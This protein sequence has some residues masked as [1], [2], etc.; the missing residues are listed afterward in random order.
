VR[1]DVDRLPD[2]RTRVA[3]TGEIDMS[4][5]ADV[6]QRIEAATRLTGEVVVDLRPL[7]YLDSQGVRILQRLVNRHV[8]GAVDVT[9]VATRG[10]IVAD[11][12][13]MT[14]LG[15]AVPVVESL[16]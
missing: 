10:S 5:A 16:E 14:H 13:A 6:E 9:L 11:L 12:L 7:K 2:G 1:V 8:A 4:N 15:D 3:L